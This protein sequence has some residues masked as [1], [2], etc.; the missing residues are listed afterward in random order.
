[1]HLKYCE[2]KNFRSIKE[3]KIGFENNFQILVGLNEAGKSNILKAMSFIRSN[4]VPEDDDVRDPRHDETPIDVAYVRF[5]FGLEKAETQ[6]IFESL[7]SKFKAKNIKHPIIQIGSENYSLQDFCNYKKDGLYTINLLTKKKTAQHWTL[8]GS[9][10]TI[11]KSWKKVPETWIEY[12]KFE[13]NDFR[14]ICID[15]Y[16]E[17]RDDSALMDILLDELNTLVGVKITEFV[18]DE[19]FECIVWDYKENNLLP[20]RIDIAAFKSNPDSCEPLRNIFYLAGYKDIVKTISDAELKTNGMRNL[21]RKLSENATQHLR[22]VWPEY[23]KI[24]IELSQ[25]GKVIEAGIVDEFNVYSLKRRSDGFKRFVTFLLMISAKVKADYLNNTIIIIDEPD[26]GLHPSGV[27]FLREELKK[28]SKDNIVLVASHS[29]FMI[30]KDRID[31]HLIVK[32]EKEETTITSNYSSTMLDEEVIFRALGYSFFELLKKRNVIFEGWSDKFTFQKWIESN[33]VIKK[34][35][36][37]IGMIHAL[38]AKDVDRVS[39]QLENL[40]RECFIITD[41]DEPSL[42]WQKKYSGLYNWITYKDLGFKNKETIEDFINVDYVQKM[43]L[44]VLQK[45]QLDVGVSLDG[46]PTFN[47]KMKKLESALGVSKEEF[48]RLKTM[49]KNMIFEGLVPKNIDLEQLI[50][51]VDILADD[52]FQPKVQNQLSK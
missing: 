12:S 13:S 4:I 30:D 38:G 43:I 11:S 29:I 25:N 6:V 45:E 24:S 3:L 19:L 34:D 31:R 21:L 9:R 42:E 39:S 16:P 52:R 33:K 20:E 37:D 2:I 44:F 48:K 26:I 28:I 35:W 50:N 7:K 18:I 5:G 41:A 46:C 51:A 47:S 17:Y 22:R 49:I 14:Y 15:D 27:Q 1:M 40:N 23:R 36:K 8:A 10:Y 32:K